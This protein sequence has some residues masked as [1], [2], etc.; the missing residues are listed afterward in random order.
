MIKAEIIADSISDEWDCPQRITSYILTYPRFIHSELMTHRVFSRN[1]A[2]SRAIPVSK[3]INDVKTNI[4]RPVF[5]GRNQK[6]MQAL[7]ALD[8]ETITKCVALWDEAAMSA[9][10]YAQKLVDLGAHKQI[11]NRVIEP[12]CHMTTLL[13]GTDFENFFVLRA[14]KDAQ[15]EFRVLATEM[16]K[17]YVRNSPV[18]MR[19][20][21]FHIPFG[22]YMPPGISLE[23]RLK[24][25]TARAARVSYKTFDGSFDVEKDYEL[26]DRLLESGHMSPF[27]HCAENMSCEAY[28]GNFCGW[29]QYRKKF[30]QENKKYVDL[31]KLLE[32]LLATDN[33]S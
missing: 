12:F 30:P 6:G 24:I 4:A 28:F 1:A 31:E 32:E 21:E 14:H 18:K 15:P 23:N 27:E 2:S 19:D 33:N 3:L 5:W 26:H 7:E 25:A 16:L 20:G 9:C 22:E 8:T 11:A 17:L 13:T 10:E 29:R